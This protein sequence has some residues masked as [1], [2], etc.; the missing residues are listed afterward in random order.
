MNK[1]ESLVAA[2]VAEIQ[3][4]DDVALDVFTNFTLDNATGANLDVFGVIL[5]RGRADETDEVYRTILRGQILSNQGGGTVENILEVLLL[6]F[7]FDVTLFEG[8]IAEFEVDVLESITVDQA[9]LMAQTVG[10][11]KAGGVKGNLKFFHDEPVFAYDGFGGAK[12]DGGFHY[13][14][15]IDT[16]S[17]I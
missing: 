10:R 2:Y 5:G 14:S 16:G 4:L 12:Y 9:L 15:S 17:V 13:G 11:I 7:A 6:S 1:I 8:T 3:E